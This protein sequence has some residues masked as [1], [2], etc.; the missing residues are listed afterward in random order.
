[1]QLVCQGHPVRAAGSEPAGEPRVLRFPPDAEPETVF[2]F[3]TQEL[4]EAVETPWTSTEHDKRPGIGRI[5]P[6]TPTTG[7]Q[8]AAERVCIPFI[9]SP[10]GLLQLMYEVKAEQCAQS[11][12][13]ADSHGLDLPSNRISQLL[14]LLI[15]EYSAVGCNVTTSMTVDPNLGFH[16]TT[17]R[18]ANWVEILFIPHLRYPYVNGQFCTHRQLIRIFGSDGPGRIADLL[19]ASFQMSDPLQHDTL[20]FVTAAHRSLRHAFRKVSPRRLERKQA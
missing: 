17:Q 18:V 11:V 8:E 9:E 15:R 14:A 1:M 19:G 2:S 13:L 10:G 6:G 4:G 7:L 16:G 3:L 5:F 20:V 12:Q